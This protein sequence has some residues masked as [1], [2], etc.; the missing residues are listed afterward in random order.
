MC[1]TGA[2]T[3]R[4][5]RVICPLFAPKS[6]QPRLETKKHHRNNEVANHTIMGATASSPMRGT[7]LQQRTSQRKS[8]IESMRSKKRLK[9]SSDNMLHQRDSSTPSKSGP[10]SLLD[11]PNEILAQILDHVSKP[12]N[13]RLRV[14]LS[15]DDVEGP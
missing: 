8:T 7:Q 3:S 9:D 15:N 5:R 1:F 13:I 4:P 11:V 14:S 12:C 2:N 6:C 10:K